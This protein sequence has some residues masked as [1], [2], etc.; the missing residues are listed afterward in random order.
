M[1]KLYGE[2]FSLMHKF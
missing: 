2:G 1:V